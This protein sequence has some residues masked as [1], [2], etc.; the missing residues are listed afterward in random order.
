MPDTVEDLI[1]QVKEACRLLGNIRL[2]YKD[3]DFRDAFVNM[4]LT[5][6]IKDL[7]LCNLWNTLNCS[8]QCRIHIE[9]ECTN[10]IAVSQSASGMVVSSSSSH[11]LIMW[12]NDKVP[13]LGMLLYKTDTRPLSSELMF[14]YSSIHVI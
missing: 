10:L 8:N 13:A 2:L 1:E 11:R 7:N 14:R 6:M 4:S 5:S 9:E 12:L 3:C